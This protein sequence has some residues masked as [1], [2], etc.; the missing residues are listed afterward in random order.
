MIV[1]VLGRKFLCSSFLTFSSSNELRRS[2]GQPVPSIF[3]ILFFLKESMAYAQKLVCGGSGQ[4][5]WLRLR[6]FYLCKRLCLWRGGLWTERV[7]TG[8][9]VW[10]HSI[11]I[12][13]C[14]QGHCRKG[15]VGRFWGANLCF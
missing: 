10:A 2:L 7:I 15:S 1:I 9:R 6:V 11:Y 8:W 4:R 3:F 12:C 5:W 14:R 13:G